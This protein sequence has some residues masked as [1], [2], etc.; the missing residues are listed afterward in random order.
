MKT[1]LIV[2]NYISGGGLERVLVDVVNVLSSHVNVR[3]LSL[4]DIR[5][6]YL[7][8]VEQKV[9]VDTLDKYR[10]KIKNRL[11][12][13]LYS[14]LYD[15]LF[16]QRFLFERYIKRLL[17]DI[18]IAFAENPTLEII[19]TSNFALWKKIAWIHTDFLSDQNFI[20]NVNQ[21]VFKKILSLYN[22]I[23][24]VSKGLELKFRNQYELQS[25]TCLFNTIDLHRINVLKNENSPY[26]LKA[27]CINF[28]AIGRLA[29]E[30]AFC[31]LLSSFSKLSAKQKISCHLTI[32]G[33]GSDFQSLQEY[34]DKKNLHD[35]V[36][37]TGNLPNPYPLLKN[38]DVLLQ[39]S[40]YEGF[41]LVLLEAMA[42]NVPVVATRTI[43]ATDVLDNGKYGILV[44]NSDD[45]FDDIIPAIIND[46][47]KVDKF[48]PLFTECLEKY[49]FQKF[50]YKL[51]KY[52]QNI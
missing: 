27:G 31:R 7:L 49:S 23:I 2:V 12:K 11:L 22:D 32:I 43:G 3:V 36:T 9:K 5:S 46:R 44:E 1:V 24:F 21:Q 45:A 20:L 29:K 4:Y 19:A 6:T 14:R 16:I 52:I 35:T 38:A 13:A 18:Q 28:I 39:S 15:K 8:E 10:Y 51:L 30:K 50:E 48:K 26:L 34:V 42:L 33:G 47:S 41:G 37:L 40:T 17:P 25:T